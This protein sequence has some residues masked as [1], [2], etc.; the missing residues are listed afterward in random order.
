MNASPIVNML[1]PLLEKHLNEQTL[2]DLFAELTQEARPPLNEKTV[3]LISQK[4]D[5]STVY[6]VA[7]INLSQ[8]LTHVYSQDTLINAIKKIL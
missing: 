6:T 5:G 4:A 2:H 1:R 3:I 7:D 8:Q